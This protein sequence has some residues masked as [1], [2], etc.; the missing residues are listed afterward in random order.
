[1][2]ETLQMS[3]C[4]PGRDPGTAAH[5]PSEGPQMR[6]I[7]SSVAITT[8]LV[9]GGVALAGAANA[10]PVCG[11]AVVLGNGGGR[12]ESTPDS[13]GSFVRCDTVYV[14]GFGGT[15]CYRVYPP[16]A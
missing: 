14:L 5:L 10:D 7:I 1:M 4:D 11:G 13:D 2:F 3:G 9:A 8:A 12:C 16:A 6:K 15:Y